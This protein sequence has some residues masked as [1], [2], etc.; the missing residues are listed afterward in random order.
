[1]SEGG[2]RLDPPGGYPRGT[3]PAHPRP[4]QPNPQPRP[5]R[6]SESPPGTRRSAV[7]LGDPV[8][9]TR[10]AQ[11]SNP[12][13]RR[14]GPPRTASSTWRLGSDPGYAAPWHRHNLPTPPP[15]SNSD[16][17]PLSTFRR[18]PRLVLFFCI[19]AAMGVVAL[20][21]PALA[22]LAGPPAAEAPLPTLASGTPGLAVTGLTAAA[23][24][25]G[26]AGDRFAGLARIAGAGLAAVGALRTGAGACAAGAGA[27]DR[28][29]RGGGK[30]PAHLRALCFQGYAP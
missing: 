14:A 26:L 2:Q 12:G 23:G 15:Y 7:S 18:I 29:Y 1:M 16:S 3:G 5:R 8:E 25:A 30:Y 20:S 17:L 24:L 19:P 9:M 4:R 10:H 27:G 6:P 28:P 11:T 21:V 22:P 13:R